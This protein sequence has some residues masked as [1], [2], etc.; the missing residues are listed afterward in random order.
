MF[1]LFFNHKNI[2]Q[3]LITD[4]SKEF[5]KRNGMWLYDEFNANVIRSLDYA[6]VLPP[7]YIKHPIFGQ[8]SPDM[9]S[10]YSKTLILMNMEPEYVYRLSYVPDDRAD[11]LNKLAEKKNLCLY[12]DCEFPFAS[13]ASAY[14]PEY[15]MILKG[16]DNLRYAYDIYVRNPVRLQSLLCG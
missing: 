10:R 3:S 14:L 12:Y 6:E 5:T 4:V 1:Y 13:D 16:G 11:L 2:K 15:K 7:N 9:I 8:V